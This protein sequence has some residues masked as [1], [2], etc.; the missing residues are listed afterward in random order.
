MNLERVI[1]QVRNVIEHLA[2]F[3]KH[4][5]CDAPADWTDHVGGFTFDATM[6]EFQDVSYANILEKSGERYG[7]IIRF[8]QSID[9]R[10][11]SELVVDKCLNELALPE[12]IVHGDLWSHNLMWTNND[13]NTLAAFLDWQLV[14]KGNPLNE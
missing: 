3:H 1:L 12:L 13:S 2:R 6:D 9:N 5:M 14:F 4:V 7:E 11:F 8:I 10:K